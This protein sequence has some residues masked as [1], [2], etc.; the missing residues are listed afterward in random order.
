M[1]MI[2]KVIRWICISIGICAGVILFYINTHVYETDYFGVLGLSKTMTYEELAKNLG[3]KIKKTGSDYHY[4]GLTL[5]VSS[6]IGGKLRIV[7]VWVTGPRYRFGKN[8]LG[9]GSTLEEVKASY[10]VN[11]KDPQPDGSDQLRR[12]GT[13]VYNFIDGIYPKTP[14]WSNSNYWVHYFVNEE[15]IVYEIIITVGGP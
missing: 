6:D 10:A 9:V 11:D 8:S 13:E 2:V 12:S 5:R 15:K 1:R 3:K 4:D 14:Y 7:C